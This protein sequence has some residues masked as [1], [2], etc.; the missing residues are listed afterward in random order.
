M[1]YH[2]LDNQVEKFNTNF[3]VNIFKFKRKNKNKQTPLRDSGI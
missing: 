3:L 1:I 2:L